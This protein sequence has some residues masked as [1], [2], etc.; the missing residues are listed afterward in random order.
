MQLASL[1]TRVAKPA[2]LSGYKKILMP[3]LFKVIV[4]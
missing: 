1:E 3:P 4:N 2:S